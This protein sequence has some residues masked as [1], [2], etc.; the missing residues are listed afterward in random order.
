MERSTYF[1]TTE[2]QKIRNSQLSWFLALNCSG[3]NIKPTHSTNNSVFGQKL[4][5]Y[6]CAS[7]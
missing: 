5:E 6:T 7:N 1:S 4:I 3:F 2:L